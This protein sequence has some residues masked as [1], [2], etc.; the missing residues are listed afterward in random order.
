M[1]YPI[2]EVMDCCVKE[3]GRP[4]QGIFILKTYEK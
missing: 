1:I 3:N 2:P 4:I